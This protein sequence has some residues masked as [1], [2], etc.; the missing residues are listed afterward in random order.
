M[1]ARKC[2]HAWLFE[3]VTSTYPSCVT[4][5]TSVHF[6]AI[7]YGSLISLHIQPIH[8]LN[9]LQLACELGLVDIEVL[10]RCQFFSFHPSQNYQFQ[11]HSLPLSEIYVIFIMSIIRYELRAVRLQKLNQMTIENENVSDTSAY[12]VEMSETKQATT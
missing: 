5:V 4:Y 7:I 3:R 2:N 6:T 12:E 9:W 8:S 1:F 10:W 11:L